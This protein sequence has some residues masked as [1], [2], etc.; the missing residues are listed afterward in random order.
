MTE[1]LQDSAER[2]YL[3][4]VRR[5]VQDR[6]TARTTIAC[7]IPAYNEEDTIAEVLTALLK[8]TRLPD[9]IHVVINNS[10]DETFLRGPRVR[11]PARIHLPGRHLPDRGLYPRHRREQGQEGRG[12]QLR[13]RPGMR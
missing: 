7:V 11:R 8:Q 6:T 1:T 3:R 13:L 12:L 9:V 10:D 2:D 5:K 4:V